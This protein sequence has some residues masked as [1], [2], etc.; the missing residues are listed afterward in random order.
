MYL[1]SKFIGLKEAL[2]LKYVSKGKRQK[3]SFQLIVN[4]YLNFSARKCI[5]DFYV[6]LFSLKT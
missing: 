4:I 6:I 1:I 5:F 3:F 2:H